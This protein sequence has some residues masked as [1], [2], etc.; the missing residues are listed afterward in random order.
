MLAEPFA[1]IGDEA[2]HLLGW[3]DAWSE[4]RIKRPLGDRSSF[5]QLDERP[6]FEL[7][8]HHSM[9]QQRDPEPLE[10]S[11]TQDKVGVRG[12]ALRYLDLACHLSFAERPDRIVGLNQAIMLHQ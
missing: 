2:V 7:V 3:G 12:E 1:E 6:P 5:Q 8:I 9:G 4:R 11:R 10:S